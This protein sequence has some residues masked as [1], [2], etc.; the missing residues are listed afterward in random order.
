MIIPPTTPYNTP[1]IASSGPFRMDNARS[2]ENRKYMFTLFIAAEH[3]L[4]LDIMMI[5]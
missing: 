3:S 2:P 5:V 4:L 1:T